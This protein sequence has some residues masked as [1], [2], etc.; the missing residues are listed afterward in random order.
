MSKTATVK[1]TVT[2]PVESTTSVETKS[3]AEVL[4]LTA[5][6][7]REYSLQP[8]T[9]AR[10]RYLGKIWGHDPQNGRNLTSQIAQYAGVIYPHARNTLL[11]KLKRPQAAIPVVAKK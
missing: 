5:A 11:R 8:T 4:D 2:E 7:K 1:K 9:A 3:K 6:Q 10:I